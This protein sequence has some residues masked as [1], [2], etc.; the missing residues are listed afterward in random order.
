MEAVFTVL[1]LSRGVIPPTLNLETPDP[2]G[3]GF[4]H[5]RLGSTPLGGRPLRAAL[6]NSFG[7]GG[8]NASA[9]FVAPGDNL[10]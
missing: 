3:L 6:C 1:A 8:M 5:V 9:L 10:A 4:E 2:A 7:F